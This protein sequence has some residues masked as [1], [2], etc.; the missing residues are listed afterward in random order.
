MRSSRPR[1]RSSRTSPAC[2]CGRRP[3]RRD[4]PLVRAGY[5]G[6]FVWLLP[7]AA[8]TAVVGGSSASVCASPIGGNPVAERAERHVDHA[9]FRPADET[10]ERGDDRRLL[11]QPH[12][13][14]HTHVLDDRLRGGA[15]DDPRDEHPVR[16]LVVENRVVRRHV[17]KLGGGRRR[18][19]RVEVRVDAGVVARVDHG[20][21][22][23]R[24][25][26]ARA[27]TVLPSR[28]ASVCRTAHPRTRARRRGRSAAPRATAACSAA[29]VRRPS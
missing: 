8:M 13:V 18:H 17:G 1:G 23:R 15:D 6:W 14:E 2:R 22:V 9:H 11:R 24:R 19:V 16:R 21:H 20:E 25:T 3:R 5:I 29:S 26:A 4:R 28:S 27:R 12:S 7:A 10:R